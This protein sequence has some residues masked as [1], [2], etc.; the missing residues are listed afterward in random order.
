MLRL[1]S[2]S[3][4]AYDVLCLAFIGKSAHFE[5]QN[6]RRKVGRPGSWLPPA[7]FAKKWQSSDRNWRRL[8]R[9]ARSCEPRFAHHNRFQPRKRALQASMAPAGSGRPSLSGTRSER[10]CG[11]GRG[12]DCRF[13]VTCSAC[14][15]ASGMVR[16]IYE[17]LVK[18]ASEFGVTLAG[19]DTAQS[20]AGI[21]ADV[22]VLGS[23][24]KG[25]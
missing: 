16:G 9:I 24:P 25:K 15:I 22:I 17:G 11:H 12:T 14:E 8:R 3:N 20:P 18:L 2:V 5:D 13:S 23:V 19:G 6:F 4:S 21:L 7:G 1:G 10:Y